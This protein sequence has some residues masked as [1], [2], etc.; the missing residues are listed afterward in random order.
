MSKDIINIENIKIKFNKTDILKEEKT[1]ISKSYLVKEDAKK[2]IV[3]SNKELET[4]IE[5]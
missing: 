1:M 3:E 5:W 2:Y 4:L